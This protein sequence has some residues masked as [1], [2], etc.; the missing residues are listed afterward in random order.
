MSSPQ[1]LLLGGS[2]QV[3][4]ELRRTLAPLGRLIVA[5]RA[6]GVDLADPDGLRRL[7]DDVRPGVIVNAAA[8]TAVDRAEAEEDLAQRVNGLAPGV[9]GEWAASRH[10]TV[11]HYSTDY[12]F[13]GDKATPYRES[14]APNP[15]NAYGRTK[16]AGED[17][18]LASGAAALILR[19][20]WVYGRRGGNFLR[21][22][23][24]LMAERDR[25][26]IVDDQVGAPTWSRMI[27]EASLAVLA[28]LGGRSGA[29]RECRGVYHL[30]P[31]G[32][33]SWYGFAQRIRAS[34]GYAC[35]LEPI[36]TAEYP[37]PARR[38]R[39]SRLDAGK[40]RDTFGL[41]LPSWD[42][43]FAL[44]MEPAD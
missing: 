12:V 19:V 11:L 38:P 44:C 4:W 34:G 43:A 22:M 33:T 31:S 40:L 18:L 20:S 32:S 41:E 30:A 2:G 42:E 26:R 21:T 23:Q 37:T 9:I 28:A 5:G 10:A 24:R 15:L 13:D 17:A 27:A 36:T 39:N 25:L 6:A 35:E 16:L 1:I 29:A 7:L 3:G 14:D 8:Y